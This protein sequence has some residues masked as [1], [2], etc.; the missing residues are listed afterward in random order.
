[1]PQKTQNVEIRI[2]CVLP[3]GVTRKAARKEI[4]FAMTKGDLLARRFVGP[5]DR[6]CIERPKLVRV[7]FI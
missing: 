3:P 1:M 5:G 4:V 2:A 7:Q 6:P